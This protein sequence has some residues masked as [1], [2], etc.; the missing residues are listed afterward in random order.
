MSFTESVDDLVAADK[1]GLLGVHPTWARARVADVCSI[2]NGYPFSSAQFKASGGTPLLR[3]R[4]VLRGWTETRF[5]GDFDPTYIVRHGELVVGMDGDF[6]CARWSGDDALLNQRVCKLTPDENHYDPRLLAHVLPGYL[7]AINSKTSAMTVKHLSSK[8]VAEIP[9]PLPPRQEQVR[10]AEAI[11]SH[12]TRLDDAVATLERVQRNLKRY[13]ASVLKAAFEGRLVPTEAELARVEGRSY[14]RASVLLERLL[15]ERRC[16]WEEAERAK[17][18]AKGKAP[19]DDRWKA[20]YVEAIAPDTADLPELP[21]GWC[22]SS[23]GELFDI[24]VGA[25]PSRAKPEYWDG[26]IPWVSSGEVSFCRIARTRETISESGLRNSSTQLNPAGSVLLGMIGEGRTRGQAA[27]LT[28]PAC[29]NQNSAAIW[30]GEAGLPPEYV[31]YFL[32]GQYDVTRT[33]G[34]GNSQPAL[35]RSRVQQIL[36]PIPPLAEAKRIVE[37]IEEHESVQ[38]A[39]DASTRLSMVRLARLRQSILKWAFEGRLVDQDPTDEPASVLLERIRAERASATDKSS[40]RRR[41][42]KEHRP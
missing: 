42:A 4:D 40:R 39:T 2:L 27:I 8:T 20:R 41:A 3:I 31:Y 26:G 15:A 33:R 38:A 24:R 17:M 19:T 22:W 13:R 5:L 7:S 35:N 30:V 11:E 28:V 10:L 34:S 18:E 37:Q 36:I 29:N 25:T 23:L 1:S 16:R 9:L 6:H 32:M 12:F 21:E 14:E